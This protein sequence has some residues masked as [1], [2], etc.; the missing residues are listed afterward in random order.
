L[1]GRAHRNDPPHGG[2]TGKYN[3][4]DKQKK[5][6]IKVKKRAY[7]IIGQKAVA[8]GAAC[9]LADQYRPGDGSQRVERARR[10]RGTANAAADIA[11]P[12]TATASTTTATAAAAE[13]TLHTRV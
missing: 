8:A 1:R 13:T 6:Y 3:S 4:D 9:A 11:P 12:V 10:V 5:I 2:P 7:T